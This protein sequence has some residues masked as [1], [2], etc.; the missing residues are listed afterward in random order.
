MRLQLDWDTS[1]IKAFEARGL[2]KALFNALK[3]AGGDAL[4][5]TKT[6]SSRTVRFR[7]A[8][9]AGRLSK[10]LPLSFPRGA[11]DISSLVWEMR[12]SGDVQP[13]SNFPAQQQ[14]RGV[15]ATINKGRPALL[16]SAFVAT[17]KSGHRGVF[18]RKGEARLPIKELFTTRINDVFNDNGMIDA[19]FAQAQKKFAASFERLL[20]LEI[21]K[22]G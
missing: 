8:I 12:V 13:V 21:A 9:K 1:Q 14:K 20:P 16:K 15:K 10:G 2:E 4:R 18:V 22:V 17:M 6:T 3:K 11:S 19:V 5:T 7:K